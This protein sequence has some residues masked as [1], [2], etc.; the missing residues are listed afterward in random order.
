MR[1]IPKT[2]PP[3]VLAAWIA[4]QQAAGITPRY[5]DFRDKAALNDHLRAEQ[6]HICCYCQ[7]RI[8]QYRKDAHNEHLIPQQGPHGDPSREVAYSN[9]YAS[10]SYARGLQP[11]KTYC[12][13][14]K[15]DRL[16]PPL[17]QDPGCAS[18]FAYNVLGEILPAC[19]SYRSY[20]DF[21]AHKPALAA[22]SLEA[23]QV[24]E[25]LNLNAAYLVEERKKTLFVLLKFLNAFPGSRIRT[26]IPALDGAARLRSFADMLLFFMRK[27]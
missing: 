15:G 5:A 21:T 19:G 25:V 4:S 8:T 24:I 17:I 2:S 13:E 18:R 1:Y 6:G 27:A 16:I 22:S 26:L 23:L 14:A 11:G 9:L 3:P 7:Q 12:G 20:A 10:C